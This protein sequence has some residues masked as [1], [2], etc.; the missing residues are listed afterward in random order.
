MTRAADTDEHTPEALIARRRSVNGLRRAVSECRG[1]PLWRG[2][3]QAVFGTGPEDA[4]LMLIGETP[5][6]REDREGK[7]FVGPAGRLLREALA[8]VGVDPG[9]VYMTNA[10]KHF[11]WVARGKRRIHKTPS[12][13]EVEACHP[14]LDA[15]LR[16]VGP[17]GVGLLGATAAKTLLGPG[18]RVTKQRGELL[19]VEFADYAVATVH[20]SS[21]LRGPPE[22]R[23]RSFGALV[24]DLRVLATAR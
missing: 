11:K 18:F 7:P 22:Q 9:S 8:E 24:E 1:C 23:K 20:P 15:E 3:T 2:A 21:I 19:E 16:Q 6:D 17:E 12:K 4:R 14:W 10:V 5:G 13:L